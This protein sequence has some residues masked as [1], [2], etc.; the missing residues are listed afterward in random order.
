MKR[1]NILC[2]SRSVARLRAVQNVPNV[3]EIRIMDPNLDEYSVAVH[4][5]DAKDA[6]KQTSKRRCVIVQKSDIL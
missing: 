3:G 4:F 6:G 2:G 5:R 1:H